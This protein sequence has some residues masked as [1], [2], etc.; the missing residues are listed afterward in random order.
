MEVITDM[1]QRKSLTDFTNMSRY[2]WLIVVKMI[3][4]KRMRTGRKELKTS[5]MISEIRLALGN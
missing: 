3:I 2:F 5:I 1:H 4:K